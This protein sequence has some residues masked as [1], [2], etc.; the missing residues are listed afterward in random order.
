MYVENDL[1]E[2]VT[3]DD[4]EYEE[5]VEKYEEILVPE[6]FPES[7]VTD[8]TISSAPTQGKPRC[9]THIFE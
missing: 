7:P 9:I 5:I 8:T 1:M 3:V 6:E 4:R 2:F